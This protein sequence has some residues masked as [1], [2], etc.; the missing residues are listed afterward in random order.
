MGD[1][2][3][4]YADKIEESFGMG[5]FVRREFIEKPKAR[6][7]FFETPEFDGLYK[8]ISQQDSVDEEDLAYETQKVEG[9]SRD[10]FSRLCSSVFEVLGDKI[11]TDVKCSVGSRSHINYKDVRFYLICGQGSWYQTERIQ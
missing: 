4:D 7:D 10:D 3:K 6:R 5:D 11:Q 8:I 2:K 9:L 1:E